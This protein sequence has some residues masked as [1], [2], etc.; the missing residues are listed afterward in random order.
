M[1]MRDF[2]IAAALLA[3][4]GCAGSGNYDPRNPF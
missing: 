3:L 2:H 4:A 1:I